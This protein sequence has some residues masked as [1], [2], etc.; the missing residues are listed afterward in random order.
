MT[1]KDEYESNDVLKESMDDKNIAGES[2]VSTLTNVRNLVSPYL[3]PPVLDAMSYIDSNPN[4]QSL[5]DEPS[6][7]ILSAV[8]AIIIIGRGFKFL[9]FLSSGKA[10]EG[11]D[12]DDE[13][14]EGNVLDNLDANDGSKQNQEAEYG[15]SVIFFGPSYSGKTALF[16]TLLSN[17]NGT[18]ERKIPHTVMS[19]KANVSYLPEHG[20]EA[21]NKN[22]RIVDYPGH[23]TL[24]SQLPSLLQPPSK[25]NQTVRALL[26]VDSTKVVS[27]A[28]SLLYNM[29]LT[30]KSLLEA[31]EKESKVLNIMVLCNKMD[32]TNAKNWRRVK[33]Q[34]R[35]ELE[36]LKKISSGVS[37]SSGS[38]LEEISEEKRTLSGKSIDFDDLTK[39]GLSN[40]NISFSS[41]S[42]I[43]GDGIDAVSA[44]VTG[45][46]VVTDN[47]SILT[48]RKGKSVKKQSKVI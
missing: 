9:S 25:R 34:L 27:E 41:C 10:V 23:I 1:S 33:I 39:N 29:V 8:F 19:L 22:V 20:G 43:N 35:T 40:V 31:W 26:V 24:S 4:M 21:E 42:C 18:K 17:V 3:P 48:Q 37:S 7:L 32:A 5:G 46:Q 2:A 36:K 15:D 11:L 16:Y 28:A 47:S 14:P 38:G 13:S 30:N 6:M 44:F 45:G 12:N